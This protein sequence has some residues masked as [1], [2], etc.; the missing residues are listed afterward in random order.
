LGLG[1]LLLIWGGYGIV[2]DIRDAAQV[3]VSG[4]HSEQAQLADMQKQMAELTYQIKQ[5]EGQLA[6]QKPK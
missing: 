1:F 4:V 6:T 5:L 2:A 3:S